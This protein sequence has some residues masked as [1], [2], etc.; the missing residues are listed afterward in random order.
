MLYCFAHYSF[1]QLKSRFLSYSSSLSYA[2]VDSLLCEEMKNED[3]N[4]IRIRI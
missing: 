4:I 2:H 3:I 1:N